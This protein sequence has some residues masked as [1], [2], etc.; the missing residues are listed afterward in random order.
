MAGRKWTYSQM[1][2]SVRLD[3]E[4]KRFQSEGL[5]SRKHQAEVI[6]EEEENTIWEKGLLEDTTPQSLLDSMVFCCS[7]CFALC[8]GKEQ[9]HL[10][11]ARLN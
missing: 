5:R 4:M 1:L 2:N 10:T 3:V 6:T 9:R 8:R 11:P 7:L